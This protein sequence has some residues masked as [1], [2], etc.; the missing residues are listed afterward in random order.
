VNS[1]PDVIVIGTGAGGAALAWSLSRQGLNVEA[2][3]A[4]PRYDFSRDYRLQKS[5]WE[6]IGFPEKIPT[7]DRQV[8]AP[9]Q[10][11]QPK[12]AHLRSWNIVRGLRVRSQRRSS[13][14]GYKHVVGLGGTTLYFTGEYHRINPRAMHMATDFGVAADWPLSYKELEPHYKVVEKIVGV[15][16]K[17][18]AAYQRRSS[19]YPL[20]PLPLSHSTKVLKKGFDHLGL[21]FG[22]NPLAVLSKAYDGR[23]P[24][25]FCGNCNRG[26][27]RGDKGSADLTFL[28]HAELS[29]HCTIETGAQVARLE[30]NNDRVSRVVYFDD[31]GRE[32]ARSAPIVVLACGAI[33]TPRLMMNSGLRKYSGAIGLNFMETLAWTSV[34]LHS[35]PLGS[36][37]GHPSDAICWAFNDPD[38]VN[39]VVGGFRISPGTAEANLVGPINYAAR[40][41]GSFGREHKRLMRESF[42]RALGVTAIGENLPNPRSFVDVDSRAVDAWGIPKARINSF[43]PDSELQ[44]LAVM[45]NTCREVLDAAGIE[46]LIDESGSYDEFGSSH[47]FGTCR[48]GLAAEHSVVDPWGKVH[49]TKNLYITDASVFPSSGGGESPALTISALALR[50]AQAIARGHSR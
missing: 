27:P 5:D 3:E 31:D 1:D 21:D 42:G 10:E 46:K 38:S 7:A 44:R 4:G 14:G 35:E 48:M 28:R 9:L 22:P 43:L 17:S 26:C 2:L 37:R 45:A 11:L 18:N 13:A 30:L 8:I 40:V 16:G 15:S 23:P 29:G 36:H 34:G 50:T 24:C 6:Q 25:N 33:E 49:G 39:G 20:P 12:W 47:V 32:R 19:D 41:A